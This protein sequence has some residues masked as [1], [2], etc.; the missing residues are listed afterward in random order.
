MGYDIALHG[1]AWHNMMARH[2]TAL[3]DIAG[4]KWHGMSVASSPAPARRP[5]LHPPGRRPAR[6][7]VRAGGR[8]AGMVQWKQDGDVMITPVVCKTLKTHPPP[9]P[10]PVPPSGPC[11][12]AQQCRAASAPLQCTCNWSGSVGM[13][14]GKSLAAG[15][16]V[17]IACICSTMTMLAAVC[18]PWHACMACKC[19][20]A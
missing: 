16:K 7:A 6:A 8:R 10:A 19:N 15:F 5:D 20:A 3:R 2:G 17:L 14:G 9:A 13:R 12:L 18:S 4:R 11:P 1:M